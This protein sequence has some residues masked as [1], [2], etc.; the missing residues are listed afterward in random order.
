MQLARPGS[1]AL[2]SE[3]ADPRLHEG[4]IQTEIDFGDSRRRCEPALVFLA[5]AAERADV[6]ERARFK[7]HETV[8]A[9]QLGRRVVGLLRGHHRFVEAGWQDF[10]QIDVAR[11]FVVLLLGDRA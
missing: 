8:A 9:Y 2:I 7:A 11:E 1:S 10:N 6:I 5:V 4:S 3:E